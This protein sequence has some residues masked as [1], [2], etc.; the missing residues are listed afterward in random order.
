I[1]IARIAG[2]EARSPEQ[3]ALAE[4]EP[5][6][7][8]DGSS[9]EEY[10]S[11]LRVPPIDPRR[12]VGDIHI[13][14]V[15]RDDLTLLH[16][17]VADW[18]VSHVGPLEALLRSRDASD[19]VRDSSTR[20]R[21][22]RR[23]RIAHAWVDAYMKGRGKPVDRHALEASGA[24]SN[25]FIEAVT[26]L[27]SRF[28]GHA[29]RLVDARERREAAGFQRQK[30][31]ELREWLEERGYLDTA[32]TLTA[33]ERE[34]VTLQRAAGFASPEEIRLVLASLEGGAGLAER[35]APPLPAE[36]EA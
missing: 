24:V 27:A 13:F 23:C 36:A 18:R 11:R 20:E 34:R 21:L 10:A 16:R 14:Y 29:K 17:L 26:E 3:Y 22:A 9:P 33:D 2:G 31:E 30:I 6:P 5:V 19:V 7:V 8:P 15:L 25:R 28:D 35:P 32:E 12:G 1:D 4:R